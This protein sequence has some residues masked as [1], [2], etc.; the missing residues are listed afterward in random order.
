M[1]TK[2]SGGLDSAVSEVA[3]KIIFNVVLQIS[4]VSVVSDHR[5]SICTVGNVFLTY[6]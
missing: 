5:L 6:F 3:G 4:V 2:F 1:I